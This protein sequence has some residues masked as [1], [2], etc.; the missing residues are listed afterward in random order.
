MTRVEFGHHGS[1]CGH[2]DSIVAEIWKAEVAQEQTPIGVRVGAHAT[3]A[4]RG[5]FG[6]LGPEPAL[7][8]EQLCGLIALHPLLEHADMGCVFVHLAHRDLVR[9]PIILGAPTIDLFGTCPALWCAEHDHR[10]T[11]TFRKSIPKRVVLDPLIT[12]MT[13]S[14]VVSHHLV[15]FLRLMPLDEI[16]RVAVTAEQMIQLV[17]ADP[18]ENGGIGDLVTVQ[19]KDRQNH[20]VSRRIEELVG[21]PTR[22]QWSGF[23]LAVAD[24]TGNDQIGIVEG[25]SIG[26]REGVAELTALVN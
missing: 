9:A 18:R 15:H 17:M 24:D 10:P 13:V 26:V 12:P 5:D 4:P 16:W 20:P 6:Q 8:I 2:F 1:G 11:G 7:I 25:R 22:R 14:S 3:C 23:R 19:V 21:M